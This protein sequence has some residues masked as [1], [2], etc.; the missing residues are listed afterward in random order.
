[1]KF[2][3]DSKDKDIVIMLN[4]DFD[5][6]G[7]F[8]SFDGDILSDK[9]NV[10]LQYTGYI[11]NNNITIFL[12]GEQIVIDNLIEINIDWGDGS[13]TTLN[14]L[15]TIIH[16]YSFSGDYIINCHLILNYGE[17]L[18]NKKI[19][20]PVE[21]SDFT[22]NSIV[23]NNGIH[24][25]YDDTFEL[26]TSQ[27]GLNFKFVGIGHSRLD[28]L[29]KYGT[30]EYIGTTTGTY[31]TGI[32][33]VR[34]QLDGL[35]YEDTSDGITT[36][37][38]FTGDFPDESYKDMMITRN[39]HFLGFVDGPIIQSD[40]FI[41]RGKQSVVEQNLRLC[42]IDNMGELTVYGNGFFKIKK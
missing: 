10:D 34:Y 28:E 33:W 7:S 14:S 21:P 17:L 39:E 32:T 8:C 38:G 31:P 12:K 40:V 13:T 16:N 37:T 3:K 23:L 29:K 24:M 18:L 9:N 2:L 30:D 5:A 20:L 42:E 11:N 6:L 19:K 27:G 22:F 15:G 26:T 1:M 4:N 35:T 36:I 25:T 41:D